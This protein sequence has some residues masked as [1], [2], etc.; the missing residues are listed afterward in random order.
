M[1]GVWQSKPEPYLITDCLGVGMVLLASAL[2]AAYSKV[3]GYTPRI[4]TCVER[5]VRCV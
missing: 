4:M 3:L 1:P 2:R 5:I